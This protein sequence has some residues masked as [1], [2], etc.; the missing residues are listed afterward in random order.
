MYFPILSLRQH[1]S[2]FSVHVY[3]N[4][5]WENK[6]KI[7]IYVICDG[8]IARVYSL[9]FKQNFPRLSEV[10]RKL[11]SKIGHW[12]LEERR[13]YIIIFGAT[14][15]PH[16][17]P[18]HVPDKLVLG[19]ICYQTILQ[20]FNAS[21]VKYKKRVFIPYGFYV[22]YHFVKDTTHARQEAHSQME[23]MFFTGR[24]KKHDPRKLWLS[25]LIR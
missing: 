20:G 2:E 19:E 9:I 4:I 23:Y 8:F 6:Y 18:I 14:S 1:I 3:F 15:A 24:Y 25:M 22:G 5:L 12:Y 11:I 21:L 10:V 17:L 7:S 13:T 16:L